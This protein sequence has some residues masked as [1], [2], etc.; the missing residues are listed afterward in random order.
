VSELCKATLDEAWK[1]AW[2]AQPL[3]DYP[4]SGSELAAFNYGRDCAT[5]AVK[6][7]YDI[8]PIRERRK[9]ERRVKEAIAKASV[10][11][12]CSVCGNPAIGLVS[13]GDAICSLEC[14]AQ[15]TEAG[16]AETPQ[17]GSVHDGP[18]AASD[19]PKTPHQDSSREEHRGQ[20]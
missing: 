2:K 6:A 16:T 3:P 20:H 13:A 4:V 7:L 9:H 15:G 1:A 19:A 14:A 5:A 10:S 11:P 8:H 18:V 12:L 17:S